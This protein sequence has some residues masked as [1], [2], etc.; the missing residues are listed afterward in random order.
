M[1]RHSSGPHTLSP[2]VMIFNERNECDMEKAHALKA[3]KSK[4]ISSG[5]SV[6]L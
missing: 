2:H 6:L 1:T 3:V 4:I 5:M